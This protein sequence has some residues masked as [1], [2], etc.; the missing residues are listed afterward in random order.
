MASIAKRYNIRLTSLQ[1]ANP[2][3]EPRKLKSGQI[4]N[5]PGSQELRQPGLQNMHKLTDVLPSGG[6]IVRRDSWPES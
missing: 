6:W 3:V 2:S 1:S 5:L 4:L